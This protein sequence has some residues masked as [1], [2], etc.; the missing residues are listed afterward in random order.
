MELP[1][2]LKEL[3]IGTGQGLIEL[4]PNEYDMTNLSS[5]LEEALADCEA[6]VLGVAGEVAASVN[7]DD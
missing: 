1:G 6:L 7:P 2:V 5:L 3:V 4:C